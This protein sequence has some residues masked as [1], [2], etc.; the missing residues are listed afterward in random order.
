MSVSQRDESQ[1]HLSHGPQLLG[2]TV[3]GMFVTTDLLQILLF[4]VLK[5]ES[6]ALN[7]NNVWKP[8]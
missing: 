7:T 4:L 2:Y 6:W 5:K 8:D 3:K 1:V